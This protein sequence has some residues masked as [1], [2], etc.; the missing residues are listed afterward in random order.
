[1]P[2]SIRR[3][4]TGNNADGKST[5]ADDTQINA[6]EPFGLQELWTTASVPAVLDAPMERRPVKLE[7]PR[8]ARGFDSS[9]FVPRKTG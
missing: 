2:G 8:A 9:R 4:V 3:I 7:P 1:M 5:I 6:I